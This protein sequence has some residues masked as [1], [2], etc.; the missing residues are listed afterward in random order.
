M[1]WHKDWQDAQL[2]TTIAIRRL[3]EVSG[4]M[5]QVFGPRLPI[6]VALNNAILDLT[7]AKNLAESAIGKHV[8]EDLGG[9]V[10]DE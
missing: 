5:R 8:D 10:D 3:R 4:L 7:S 2:E 6:V 9:G 1:S